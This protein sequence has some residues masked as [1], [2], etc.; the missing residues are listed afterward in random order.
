MKDL[1][2]EGRKL[3]DIFKKTINENL[4]YEYASEV[5]DAYVEMA[6]QKRT[7]GPFTFSDA[8]SQNVGGASNDWTAKT[9]SGKQLDISFEPFWEGQS[10]FAVV[11]VLDFGAPMDSLANGQPTTKFKKR[12][13]STGD[14]QKDAK[15]A[16][17]Y[18]KNVLMS[19]DIKKILGE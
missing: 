3:Q 16:M 5:Q 1:I 12:V 2:N 19:P 6:K 10:E 14:V 4:D 11:I 9:K 8:K 18:I 13:T 7:I 15:M 17:D